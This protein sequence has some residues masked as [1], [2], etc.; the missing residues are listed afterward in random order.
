MREML[1]ECH[2]TIFYERHNDKSTSEAIIQ[3]I[4]LFKNLEYQSIGI[5]LSSGQSMYSAL[6]KADISINDYKCV[7]DSKSVD[8]FCLRQFI[9]DYFPVN[10]Y[11]LT[12][13]EILLV[14]NFGCENI[15]SIN[16]TKELFIQFE[17]SGIDI[18]FVDLP[19]KDSN[20][21]TSEEDEFIARNYYMKNNL[22][23]LCSLGNVIFRVGV[24][25]YEIADLLRKEGHI[26][27]E[28]FIND[29]EAVEDN[30][31]GDNIDFLLRSSTQEA[32]QFRNK[33]FSEGMVIDLY[34]NPSLNATAVVEKDLL[35]NIVG[36]CDVVMHDEL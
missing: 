20:E 2:I 7:C 16:I 29:G 5:E 1:N 35:C 21:Y 23:E 36:L 10:P 3:L 31:Y 34:E 24:S 26:V 14:S 19:Y 22:V 32:V 15:K 33:H 8:S 12:E 17:R 11:D 25:H 6:Q 28:Y 13:K 18:H 9:R 4:P 27:E 30:P